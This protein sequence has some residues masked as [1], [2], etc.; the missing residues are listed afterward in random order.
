MLGYFLVAA[1][2][3]VGAPLRYLADKA[4][5]ARHRNGFPWGTLTVNIAGTLILGILTGLA[6]T[7]DTGSNVRLL[8]GTGLCGTLTT[9][10]T[11]SFETVQLFLH[12]AR[13]LAVANLVGSTITG[14]GAAAAGYAVGQLL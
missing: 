4:V 2:A 7:G 1:G 6:L 10:S 9:Y 11:F 5:Q 14:L 13:W 12:R 8:V 3:A